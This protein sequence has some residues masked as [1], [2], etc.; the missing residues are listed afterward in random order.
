MLQASGV[1]MWTSQPT[2]VNGVKKWNFTM[3]IVSEIAAW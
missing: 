1:T 3:V 2:G